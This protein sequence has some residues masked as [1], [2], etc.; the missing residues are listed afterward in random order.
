MSAC[1]NGP[2]LIQQEKQERLC[3]LLHS[4]GSVAVAY[5]GGVDSTYLLKIASEV[6]G[7]RAVALT[8][9]LSV[10]PEGEHAA[11][12]IFCRNEGIA[13]IIIENDI[14]TLEGF[15]DNPPNRCYLCK[16]ALFMQMQEVAREQGLAHVIDGS[17][18]D[19]A[20]DY[21]PGIQALRELG[22]I[23]PL[24]Q[25][26]MTKQDIRD[27][28]RALDLPTWD[29]PSMACLASRFT[30]GEHITL[31]ALR[32]VD[33][34]ERFLRAQGLNQVRVRITEVGTPPVS[35]ARIECD[36]AGFE[37]LA[38]TAEEA[39]AL[40]T[41]VISQLNG[42]GFTYISLDL[43]GYRSGAMNEGLIKQ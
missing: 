16:R 8:V 3:E 23:S 18:C 32:K 33:A 26:G 12:Q 31:E 13:Q 24:Q 41:Q 27:L 9:A 14:L 37:R 1:W 43:C 10:S 34:A 5:S 39:Y 15:A 20:H 25:A 35:S 7:E 2:T 17:N 38:G 6:L 29:K 40:R 11:T 21:R 42:I 30:Y 36:A 4:L 22:I 28:S 19:D